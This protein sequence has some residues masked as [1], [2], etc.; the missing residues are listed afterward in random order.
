MGI[1]VC[2]LCGVKLT[3]FNKAV[4]TSQCSACHKGTSP[5]AQRVALARVFAERPELTEEHIQN[6]SVIAAVP[7]LLAAGIV[8]EV[9][10][11]ATL[12]LAD[13]LRI[14]GAIPVFVGVGVGY[15][16][17]GVVI[18]MNRH[19]LDSA[20]WG[21]FR[22]WLMATVSVGSLAAVFM[23]GPLILAA[24]L[25]GLLLGVLAVASS[26]PRRKEELIAKL[27]DHRAQA[28]ATMPAHGHAQRGPWQQDAPQQ[29]AWHQAYPQSGQTPQ[30]Q[31][32]P[33]R[34]AQAH[35]YHRRR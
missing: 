18:A 14:R 16:A 30:P 27:R 32:D 23:E 34:R 8:A 12:L 33:H 15:F 35:E 20:R 2:S 26:D 19:L 3:I 24:L 9:I 11:F 5:T 1:E 31:D 25:A 29:G 6:R 17:G 21:T 4:G 22:N 10:F 28:A 7:W 13:E